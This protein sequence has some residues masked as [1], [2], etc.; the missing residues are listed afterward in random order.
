VHVLAPFS[1]HQQVDVSRGA[2]GA[3][4]RQGEPSDQGVPDARLPEPSG[5]LVENAPQVHGEGA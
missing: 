5:K 2:R 4:S 3:V 1:I